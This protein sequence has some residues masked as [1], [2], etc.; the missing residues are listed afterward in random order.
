TWTG[1]CSALWS[2]ACNWSDNTVPGADDTVIFDAVSQNRSATV[3]AGFGGSIRDLL[4][5]P[6][7]NSTLTLNR[8]LAVTG[9][10]EW[11]AGTIT[12]T[13]VLTNAGTLTLLGNADKNL[14]GGTLRNSGTIIHTTNV[15]D[16]GRLY[17]G[18]G[19]LENLAGGL[20]DFRSDTYLFGNSNP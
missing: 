12:G 18:G 1:G 6:E 15:A 20:Y 17:I 8:S 2:Q 7:W 14:A 5:R 19:L 10:S 16:N 9:N 4:I 3:D 13:D 11:A